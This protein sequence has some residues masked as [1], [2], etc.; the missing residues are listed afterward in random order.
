MTMMMRLRPAFLLLPLLA[1]CSS[2]PDFAPPAPPADSSYSQAGDHLLSAERSQLPVDWWHL[3]QS[4][5][6]D[7]VIGEIVAGNRSLAAAEARMEQARQLVAATEGIEAPQ[8]AVGGAAGRQKYGV[9]LF[10]PT[11]FA[12]PPFNYYEAGPTAS[13]SLD[14]FGGEKR[15]VER[16]KALADYQREQWDAVRQNLIADAALQ[17]IAIA[18]VRAEIAIAQEI[19]AG[20]RRTVELARKGRDDGGLSENDVVAAETQLA[21][22]RALLPP[23]QQQLATARHAMA[24][25][26]GKSPHEWAP[27]DFE[28]ASF[29]LPAK[30][31]MTLPSDLVR[32]RPDIRA[33]EAELHAATAAVGIAEA[34]RYPQITLTASATLETLQ[35]QNLFELNH[36]AAAVAGS[37]TQTIFDGG[38]LKAEQRSAEAALKAQSELYRQTVL[39]AFGQVAD[40][41]QALENDGDAWPLAGTALDLALH[42][43]ELAGKERDAGNSGLVPLLMAQRNARLIRLNLI[44][45]QARRLQDLAI[46]CQR[47][48]GA[49]QL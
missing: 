4:P 9:A 34:N 8:L 13:Y 6:L 32:S 38:R 1:A 47:L 15:A 12:I 21:S 31:P 48:G 42:R 26:A 28:L 41:L 3:Y 10:G 39:N 22:D 35:P 49:Y 30:L 27:P 2:G 19:T 45:A 44:A 14:L 37:V 25:L 46:L 33:A 43:A 36:A 5:E 11:N 18:A 7:R 16:Q 20:D 17:A 29:A 24:V 23:L 40:A